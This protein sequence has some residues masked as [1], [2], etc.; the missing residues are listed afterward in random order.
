MTL[1]KA[2]P[3]QID[4]FQHESIE[5]VFTTY[6]KLREDTPIESWLDC[7]ENAVALRERIEGIGMRESIWYLADLL[8]FGE[9]K[10]SED[11]A[12]AIDVHKG[13]DPKTLMNYMRVAKAIDPS[14]R[15]ENLSFAHHA[16]VYKLEPN[17]QAHYLDKAE[18]EDL[19]VKALK[20]ILKAERPTKKRKPKE[21]K[22][23]VNVDTENGTETISMD[24]TTAIHYMREAMAFIEA[25]EEI[26]SAKD[27]SEGLREDYAGIMAGFRRFARRAGFQA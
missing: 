10:W 22:I 27:W 20:A 5:G 25:Q 6:L 7:F 1:T 21:E 16:E 2:A 17:D 3:I 24:H 23:S 11:Y 9:G 8:V 13:H 19:S 26:E 14:R 12:Q 18:S 15:R 4:L